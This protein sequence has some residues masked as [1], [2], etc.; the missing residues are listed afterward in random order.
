M[1]SILLIVKKGIGIDPSYEAFDPDIIMHIN[2]VL[3]ILTQ[4]GI[5]PKE[6]F[7]ITGQDETWEDFLGES[8]TKLSAVQSYVTLKTRLLF[9]PP[10]SGTLNEQIT[11][12]ISELEWRLYSTNPY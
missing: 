4:E 5:G 11:K 12:L 6:G 2:S 1:D 10:Q 8:N 9:D 3:F 7:N